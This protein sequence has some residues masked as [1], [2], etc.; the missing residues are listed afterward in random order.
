MPI[1]PAEAP[2]ALWLVDR[3]ATAGPMMFIARSDTRLDRLARAARGFAAGRVE[4]LV[5]PPWDVLPYDRTPPSAGIIGRRVATLARLTQPADRPRLLLTSAEAALQRVPPPT[6]WN[7][8]ALTLETGQPLDLDWLRVALGERGYHVDEAVGEPGEIAVRGQVIDLFPAAATAPA[9]LELEDSR[10]AAIHTFDPATQRSLDAV[11]RVV[12][13]P[14]IEFPLDP[15]EAERALEGD[16]PPLALPS[17]RLVPLFDYT[18]GLGVVLDDEVEDRWAALREQADDAYDAS[19]RLRRVGVAAGVLPRPDRL[20][21]STAQ[22]DRACADRLAPAPDGQPEPPPRRVTELI[23]RANEAATPVVIATPGDPEKLARSLVRRGLEARTAVDWPGATTGGIACLAL[24]IDAGFR[25][26]HVLVLQAANLVRAPAASRTA[27]LDGDGAPRI[28]DIVVHA[29]HGAARLVA[30]KPMETEGVADERLALAFADGSELL[31]HPAEL[32]RIWRYGTEGSLDRIQGEAWRSKRDAIEAEV[33]ETAAHLADATAARAARHAPAMDPDRAAYDRLARRFPY[34]LSLD[35]QAA[36]DAVLADLRHGSPPM[37]RLVCGDVGF[38]K[39]EVALRA[40]AA[41]ALSGHQ[42]A[43]AAPTTVLARQH[44]ETVRRRFAGTGLRVE[45]LMGSAGPGDLRKGMR[46]GSV[47][48]VVGTQALAS[49][50]VRFKD[51]GLVVIDEEQ[52]F[53]EAQKQAM[54]AAAAHTL[55]MTATP[56]PRTMQ[57]ALVGLRE[58]SVIATAPVHRQPTRTFVLPFDP[59]LVREALLREHARAGQSFVVCPRIKDLAGMAATLAE[60]VPRLT[61]MQ[62]HGRMKPEALEAAVMSFSAGEGNVLL[63]TNIIESG[64]DIPRA[65]TILVVHADRFGLAQLHQIRGR[66]GRG[67]RRGAAYL[68]TEPGRRLA[69]PTR[70]RLHALETLG[71]L[72][73]GV[74]ISAADLDQRGAGELFG[75]AQA[76]HVS[77]LGTDLYQ[78]LLLRAVQARQGHPPPPPTPNLHVGLTGQIPA[79]LVPEPDLRLSLYRRLARFETVAEVD[80][81]AEELDDRFGAVPPPLAALL[82]LARLRCLATAAGLVRI[83]AGPRGAALTPHDPATLDDLAAR[84]EAAPR[85]GRVVLQLT[86]T[87]DAARVAALVH[88]LAAPATIAS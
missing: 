85:E 14:A 59:V 88:L 40:A 18:A 13:D 39:T 45:P 9:R 35:Q 49:E 81:F 74:A 77:A 55:V 4:L 41:V 26:E 75:E 2:L 5:L 46:D 54:A 7:G 61:V 44:L 68:L 67:A 29:E 56:I 82:A 69:A 42:V 66:V 30:L 76:G 31:V 64:L 12:L 53:G 60:L 15:E 16:E 25:T 51:L 62:A 73:A 23:R 84:F 19:R 63:A 58:V 47:H 37:D 80:D 1:L 27:L 10:I 78:H 48:I 87:D 52:R 33:A 6:A 72:G 24:D 65:N 38:G 70:A 28:G 32:D 50:S 21:L 11:D 79:D 3:A 83:D 57:S 20:Y 36:V 34:A 86:G 71:S 43:I 17:G 22:A 8:A